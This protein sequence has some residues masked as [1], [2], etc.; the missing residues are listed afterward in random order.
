[1]ADVD[2]LKD[3]GSLPE[4]IA[5]TENVLVFC[6][7]AY[8]KSRNC[9]IELHSSVKAQKK[10]IALVESDQ[11]RGG[12][13]QAQVLETLHEAEARYESWKLDNP[14]DADTIHARLFL[15]APIAWERLG[16]FQ[17]RFA[18]SPLIE[19]CTTELSHHSIP[20]GLRP[21]PLIGRRM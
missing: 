18:C 12:M 21:F 4:Y 20:C 11:K 14:P 1:M 6:T 8:F 15:E 3:I 19:L 9:T 10:M 13:T 5:K 16:A 2:D 7:D 17:V